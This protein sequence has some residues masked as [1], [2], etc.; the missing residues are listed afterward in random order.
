MGLT[1]YTPVPGTLDIRKAIC[2]KFKT[3]NGLEYDPSQIVVSNGA[4]QSIIN[5]FL[6][7]LDPG[8][9]VSASE[10]ACDQARP[11]GAPAGTPSSP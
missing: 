7:I 9:E 6:S 5:I 11:A 8:D 1:K 10:A 2:H 4:K 3:E